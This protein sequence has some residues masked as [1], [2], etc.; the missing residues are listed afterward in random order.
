MHER[1][2]SY[3]RLARGQQLLTVH[4]DVVESR[5]VL[6]GLVSVQQSF[7]AQLFGQDVTCEHALR[8]VSAVQVV[9]AVS[10][11]GAVLLGVRLAAEVSKARLAYESRNTF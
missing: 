6:D 3:C 9:H 2:V 10:A 4:E 7:F 8:D 11:H 1:Q 5:V